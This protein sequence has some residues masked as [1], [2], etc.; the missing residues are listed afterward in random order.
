MDKEELLKKYEMAKSH[1]DN[2][3]DECNG[4]W[5]FLHGEGQWDA[6]AKRSRDE[7]GRPCLTLNQML[8][9]AQQ[10]V[11]DIRQA[12]M[13]IRVSPVDDFA[14][15]ETAD[16]LQGTIRNIERQSN[17]ASVYSTAALN[18]VGA[19][20]GWIKIK[21]DY[22]DTD[23]FEQ[24]AYIERVLDFT[25]VYLD[26]SSEALDGSDAECAFILDVYTKDRFEELWP[27]EQPVSFDSEN[28]EEDE[29]I[30]AECYYKYYEKDT[31]YQVRLADGST[32]VITSEQK[33]A[34]DE[35]NEAAEEGALA[36]YVAYEIMNE[37]KVEY[38]YVKKCLYAGG[39]EPLEEEE[40][41]SK[42]IPLVPVI[43][44]EVYIN[45]Q[46][47]FHSLIRQAKDAQRM[48]NYHKSASTEVLALQPKTPH[49]GPKG[50]FASYPNKWAQANSINFSHLEYD[51]VYDENGQRAEPPQRSAPPQGSPASMQEAMGAREDIRL[52]IGM[53][54]A[55]MGE[56]GREIS[57]VAIRNRQIEGDNA[58]FHFID[59]LA[60]SISQVGRIL[61][62]IIANIYSER[63][64]TRIIGEDGVEKNVPVNQPYVKE[65]GAV[66]PVRPN[67]VPTGVYDLSAGKYDVVCDVGASYSSKRQETADK[68][69]ELVNAQPELIGTVGDMIFDVLDVPRGKE[70]AERIRATMDP[71]ILGEDPQAAKLQQAAAAM[72]QMEE[73]LLN[74]QA[75]LEDKKAN[76]EFEQ[77]VEL[78]KLDQERKKIEIDAAKAQADIQ[79]TQADIEKMRA[80]TAG[81]NMEAVT[82]LGNAMNGINA[83]VQDIG[84]ALELMMDAK[85]AE[86][87]EA[88]SEPEEE[89]IT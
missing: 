81:F 72:K 85:E 1:Y 52:A 12:K 6:R 34:I 64:I 77:N 83:Q 7:D 42:Y 24:E 87:M 79:K 44:E 22:A 40:F 39:E 59:N 84:Q 57:G 38:P 67:E 82:A 49:I 13:A 66:R 25:S 60:A 76:A 71:S 10:V 35:N 62:D 5:R 69:I 21:T 55:N 23:T 18:A 75:A 70:I 46:R 17:A 63:T 4:D 53:P 14:D 32:Q 16:V 88:T 50:S 3:Y 68:L 15:V 8:P 61:V 41:P 43:G 48:Y 36:T 78:K 26:P 74:Y 30:V 58:T 51:I 9:Y 54:Q 89:E 86:L 73:Q 80:E 27:D 11:N 31:L 65:N 20:I 33:A 2:L 45:D 47:E 28:A 19:G 56:A 29:I 37:R